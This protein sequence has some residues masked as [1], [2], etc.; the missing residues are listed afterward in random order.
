MGRRQALHPGLRPGVSTDTGAHTARASQ[1]TC[2]WRD[3]VAV[4]AGVGIWWGLPPPHRRLHRLLRLPGCTQ[5][6]AGGRGASLRDAVLDGASLSS[7]CRP[8]RKCSSAQG[9]PSS[10]S[11]LPLCAPDLKRRER[12][13]FILARGALPSMA[14][15][16]SF[17]RE[18][19]RGTGTGRPRQQ[20]G[21]RTCCYPAA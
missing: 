11:E 5:Q 4:E 14:M 10:R 15:K 3:A 13:W 6:A 8:M 21:S 7:C 1:R 2:A 19:G 18:G 16:R 20:R 9:A 17:C 12:C